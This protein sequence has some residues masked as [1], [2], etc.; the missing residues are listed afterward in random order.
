MDAATSI[1]CP[2]CHT[3]VPIAGYFCFHCGKKLKDDGISTSLAR[4][5]YV[6]FGS[7][8]LP[9]IGFWWGYKYLKQHDDAS[10]KIGIAAIVLTALSLIISVWLSFAAVSMIGKQMNSQMQLYQQISY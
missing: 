9:P 2:H 6:Y 10:K 3:V 1:I 8:L 7:I 4:Q 5:I